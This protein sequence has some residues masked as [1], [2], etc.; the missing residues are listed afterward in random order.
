MTEVSLVPASPSSP[1]LSREA[2]LVPSDTIAGRALV[3]VIAIMTFLACLTA[4]GALLVSEA[5]QGWRSSVSQ[6][7]TIQIKP[8][9][10]VDIEAQVLKAA[11]AAGAT[12]GVAEVHAMTRQDS[13]RMLEPWLGKGLDL[14]QLPVPRLITVRM[15]ASASGDLEP[16]RLALKTA[17]ADASVDDHSLWISRLDTMADMIVIFAVA[18]FLLMIVAMGTA[19]GFATRGAMAGA[20]EIIEVLHFVGAADIY[21][22]REFQSHFMTLGLRGAGVGGGAAAWFFALSSLLSAYWSRSDGGEQIAALFGAFGL[23]ISGYFA[24]ALICGAIAILTGVLSRVIAF[25]QLHSL[26]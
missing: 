1:T 17:A 11:E 3:I 18:L 24:I 9:A 7:V 26:L 6:D 23:G 5:S 22:A 25:H 21:I 10:G 4:G 19:I 2:P 8:H 16:L 12:P 15:N 13:E 14:S 20:K